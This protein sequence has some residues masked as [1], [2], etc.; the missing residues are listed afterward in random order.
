MLQINKL[1]DLFRRGSRPA[2]IINLITLYRIVTAPLL[3]VLIFT[4]HMELFKWLL[5][6]SLLTD[7]FDGVLARKYKV[8][9]LLG[10]RLDSIGDDLTILIGIT[11]V[12][13]FRYEFMMEHLYFIVGLLMLHLVELIY[14]LIKWGKMTTFHTIMAKISMFFQSMF[15]CAALFFQEASQLLFFSA[16]VV[17]TIDIIEEI[18]LV[19]ILKKWEA[20]VK[21]IYWVLRRKEK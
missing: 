5:L 20:N 10:A 16:V 13:Y 18:T 12:F 2:I 1:P 21:G 17:T 19:A 9:S 11:G 8:T 7:L 14:A 3:I 15:V 6:L 4:N